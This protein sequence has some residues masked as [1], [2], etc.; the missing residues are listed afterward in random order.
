MQVQNQVYNLVNLTRAIESGA[1]I[2]IN[3]DG[4]W[5]K[6]WDPLS[7]VSLLR[8]TLGL[9]Q[10]D[11]LKLASLVKR[12]IKASEIISISPGV[13]QTPKKL[14][15]IERAISAVTARLQPQ[16]NQELGNLK[17]HY[18]E[19]HELNMLRDLSKDG[20]CLA[21]KTNLGPQEIAGRKERHKSYH[22]QIDQLMG[23]IKHLE[24][25]NPASKKISKLQV[26]LFAFKMRQLEQRVI[27][28]NVV[29]QKDFDWLN[30]TIL[31][32]KATQFPAIPTLE[33]N[34]LPVLSKAELFKIDSLCRKYPEAV[35][36]M[37]T[38][39]NYKDFICKFVFKNTNES[40]SNPVD[41]AVQFPT[42][43]KK[44]S[45][46]FIDKRVKRQS[47]VIGLTFK[48]TITDNN[49]HKDVCLRIQN[50]DIPIS[51]MSR[52]VTFIDKKMATE[53]VLTVEEIF[54]EFR[55]KDTTGIS[56]FEYTENG[57][58]LCYPKQPNID[59]ESPT[60]WTGLPVVERLSRQEVEDKY[61]VTMAGKKAVLAVCATREKDPFHIQGNHGWIRVVI[62]QDDETF[63]VHA[64]GKYTQSYPVGDLETL[65]FSFKT[66]RG[67]LAT[68]DEN[69]LY[70]HRELCQVPKALSDAQFERLMAKLKSDLQDSFSG[71]M[72][73]Q[74]QGQNCSA[75]VQQVL[76]DVFGQENMPRLF[77][78]PVIETSSPSPIN[79]VLS[80]IR[81]L[82]KI[83]HTVAKAARMGLAI[84]LGGRQKVIT[85]K[86]G[87]PVE[88][89]TITY[90]PW[91]RGYLALPAALFANEKQKKLREAF[92]RLV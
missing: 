11:N 14:I 8:R 7:L 2:A 62:P 77:N 68:I 82:E 65:L 9:E 61:N 22:A 33:E 89:S 86:N 25:N 13:I 12:F 29:N 83:S 46:C 15:D 20:I 74:A 17:S 39:R 69:E 40:C 44:I 91:R 52:K 88:N 36:R 58:D 19:L 3:K 27:S 42:L 67:V 60:W 47:K 37:R 10:K 84:L 79:K 30:E 34:G 35:Q 49:V 75:W 71:N 92:D 24:S 51:D 80:G 18:D 31:K 64:L 78:M 70:A 38:S 72:V 56:H 50:K 28:G 57:I 6:R 87:K 45:A 43:T 16:L 26:N 73:F 90:E 55:T 48:E 4:S 5:Q 66:H 63:T 54:K 85:T 81:W 41:I 21:K 1:S 32:W 59:F 76:D 23:T 53:R